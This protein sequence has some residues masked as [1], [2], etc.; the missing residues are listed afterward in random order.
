MARHTGC[1]QPAQRRVG[2][3]GRQRHPRQQQVG[4]AGTGKQRVAQHPQKDLGAGLVAGGVERGH[5]ERLDQVLVHGSRQAGA[6]LLHRQAGCAVESAQLPAGG[7][8]QQSQPVRPAPTRGAQHA[9]HKGRRRSARG[10][11]QPAAVGCD[12]GEWPAQQQCRGVRTHRAHQRQR[13]GVGT[14]QD[15]LA[16]VKIAVA[17]TDPPCPAARLAGHLE[18]G[19]VGTALH[20]PHR[21][22]QASPASA[23][24][25]KTARGPAVWP[26]QRHLP[27]QWV[28][29]A[30]HNLRSGV[31]E[32]RWCSTW[33]LS[34][35]ISRSK[36][37]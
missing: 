29:R 37:R 18:Q 11:L 25:R 35:S 31:S 22:R 34:D 30:I 24:H 27:R 9:A 15:V 26:G 10:Q 7:C 1:G 6:Q 2:Q 4:A 23:D 32:V 12:Q 19:H 5:A 28:S 36:A 8:T 3:Q 20:Q 33:K 13:G 14:D 21:S 17:G 16:V